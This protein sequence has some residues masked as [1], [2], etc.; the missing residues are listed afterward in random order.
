[1][2]QKRPGRPEVAP[3]EWRSD[4]GAPSNK[5]GVTVA[6]VGDREAERRVIAARV[7]RCLSRALRRTSSSL[8]YKREAE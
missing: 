1:M 6:Q 5:V 8:A 4:I 3:V 2:S 7:P